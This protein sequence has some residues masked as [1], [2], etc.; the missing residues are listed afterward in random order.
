LDERWEGSMVELWVAWM[1]VSM[2]AMTVV[3]KAVWMDAPWVGQ[4]VAMKAAR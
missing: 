2:D 3:M 4:S 1:V